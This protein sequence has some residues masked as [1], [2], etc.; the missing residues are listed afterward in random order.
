MG[1]RH[2]AGIEVNED[3]MAALAWYEAAAE[4]GGL[5]IHFQS[6]PR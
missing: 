5:S 1:Y 2:W 6:R 3:C 4:K